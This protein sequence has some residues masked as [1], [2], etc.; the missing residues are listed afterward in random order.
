MEGEI[1][2]QLGFIEKDRAKIRKK[3]LKKI[4]NETTWRKLM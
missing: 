4:V 2:G 3:H 1:D